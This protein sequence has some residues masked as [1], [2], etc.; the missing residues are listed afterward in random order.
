MNEKVHEVLL[1]QRELLNSSSG[2]LQES[3]YVFPASDGGL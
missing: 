2:E 1:R 3:S